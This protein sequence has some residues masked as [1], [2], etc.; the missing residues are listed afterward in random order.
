MVI[1]LESHTSH[2]IRQRTN[3]NDVF[4]TPKLLAKKQID[5]VMSSLQHDKID[6]AIWYDPFR[7]SGHYYYHFPDGNH[8]WSEILDGKD[9]FDFDKPVDIVCVLIH[10]IPVLTKFWLKLWPSN[11]SIYHIL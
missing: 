6:N 4:I 7:N 5:M 10:I 11:Q 9:F 8:E 3:P 1:Q 2:K